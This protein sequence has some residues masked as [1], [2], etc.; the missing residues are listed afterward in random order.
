VEPPS[1]TEPDAAGLDGPTIKDN[2]SIAPDTVKDVPALPAVGD[3][4]AGRY[5][6]VGTLGSG[7]MGH[8]LA[9]KH[10]ELGSRVA[11]KVL[12]PPLVSDDDAR[13]RFS[14]EA[15]AMAA[16]ESKHTVRVFDVGSLD[17]GIPYM[18]MEQLEGA[19]LSRK[20]ARDGPMSIEDACRWIDEAC[21]AVEEAHGK[22]LVHRDLKPRNLFLTKDGVRVL[23]F[24]IARAVGG[25]L[26]FATITK[27]GD[28]LG[29]LTYMAPEQIRDSK[30]VDARADVWSLGA[31]LYR[32]L[33]GAMP[34]RGDTEVDLVHG[35]L[36]SAPV[37]IATH[38]KD[39]SADLESVIRRCL[40]KEP[41]ARFATVTELRAA[42]D[43][44]RVVK[45]PQ[46]EQIATAPAPVAA[47]VP[48]PPSSPALPKSRAPVFVLV[49]IPLV[50]LIVAAYLGW[51]VAHR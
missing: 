46:S 32:L 16:L 25:K 47:P 17:N 40:E 48:E 21:V 31:C 26:D 28:M 7:G 6:I 14:R 8:V 45:P 43:A 18:V 49:V 15:R 13:Q 35:I 10:V 30:R 19:D 39:V 38:R 20:L 1:K 50:V 33:T 4:V 42:L 51:Y 12:D 5:E 2:P 11:I 37:P 34:F 9:A 41:E 36:K 24:G 44:A 3:V 22:G 29:T 23:D 27:A